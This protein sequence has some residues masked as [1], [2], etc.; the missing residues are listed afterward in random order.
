MCNKNI[1]PITIS[2][3][4]FGSDVNN[5]IYVFNR[6]LKMLKAYGKL[7]RKCMSA[8]FTII[9]R[10][11]KN[12]SV[13]N[14]VKRVVKTC[15]DYALSETVKTD[16]L[17][18]SLGT[19]LKLLCDTQE[20]DAVEEVAKAYADQG[21]RERYRPLSKRLARE[22]IRKI[23]R[24]VK[25]T[26]FNTDDK[27]TTRLVRR[28]VEKRAAQ[29]VHRNNGHRDRRSNRFRQSVRRATSFSLFI[30]DFTDYDAQ[31]RAPGKHWRV[32]YNARG[33]KVL[34]AKHSY[35]TYD[36]AMAA[37]ERYKFYNPD[38]LR[39]MSAYVCDYCGKWHIGHDR[40]DSDEVVDPGMQ[41][42]V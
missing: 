34:T 38:D 9:S 41:E 22:K 27:V 37:L 5:L 39:P 30:K 24:E 19:A 25:F 31:L 10:V 6:W 40:V 20:N 29:A 18:R 36:E 2:A 14:D 17:I 15:R 26:D 13:G 33:A 7:D 21:M 32:R 3:E 11:I 4:Q 42:A 1:L 35:N 23:G 8:D 12:G 16:S 28:I